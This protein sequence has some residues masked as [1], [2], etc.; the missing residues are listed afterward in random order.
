MLMQHE[1]S[2]TE[3]VSA[4]FLDPLKI[5]KASEE[6]LMSCVSGPTCKHIY[7]NRLYIYIATTEGRKQGCR[8]SCLIFTKCVEATHQEMLLLCVCM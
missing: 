1:V 7:E 5:K 6:P 4:C 8:C 3:E 2:L